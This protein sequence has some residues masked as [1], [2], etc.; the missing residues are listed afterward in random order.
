[1]SRW[2]RLSDVIRTPDDLVICRIAVEQG[3]ITDVQLK[4]CVREHARR[5]DRTLSTLMVEAGLLTTDQ[6]RKLIIEQQQRLLA[7]ATETA[8]EHRYCATCRRGFDE[9]DGMGRCPSCG[10]TLSTVTVA[11]PSPAEPGLPEEV[12]EAAQ[13]KGAVVGKF[14]R[15]SELGR[16]GM[17]SVWRCYDPELRRMVAIKF[18]EAEGEAVERF[19]KEARLA[20]RLEHPNIARVYEVGNVAG[21]HYIVMQYVPGRTMAGKRLSLE[22]ALRVMVKA[23]RAIHYAHEHGVIHRDLKPPNIMIDQSGE[24]YVLD[25]GLAKELTPGASS[26]RSVIM[27]TPAYMSYEQATGQAHRI[28]ARTDVYGLAATL[29]D[30]LTLRAP[31]EGTTAVEVLRKIQSEDPPPPRAL[32]PDLPWEVETILLKGLDREPARRYQSAREFADDLDR[33][34]RGDPIHAKRT[35][36]WYRLQKR[37]RRRPSLWAAGAVAVL[38]ALLAGTFALGA[39]AQRR[40]ELARHLDDGRRRLDGGDLKGAQESAALARAIDAAAAQS[41][42]D[43]VVRRLAEAD[44][45]RTRLSERERER[46]AV[47]PILR[48]LS[49]IELAGAN[50]SLRDG[51]REAEASIAQAR[52]LTESH[53]EWGS[54]W[55]AL[56]WAKR[57]RWKYGAARLLAE[58]ARD[59][60][61]RAVD[62]LEGVRRSDAFLQRGLLHA[63]LVATLAG[64]FSATI[65]D[66]GT[67]TRIEWRR[68]APDDAQSRQW[69]ARAEED[70]KRA[71]GDDSSAWAKTYGQ[72]LVLYAQGNFAQAAAR[73]EGVP[74]VDALV[75]RAQSRYYGMGDLSLL[76]QV[77]ALADLAD[78][79]DAIMLAAEMSISSGRHDRAEKLID[80]LGAI[81]RASPL[82]WMYRGIVRSQRGDA[83]GAIAAYTKVIEGHPDVPDAFMNR[84]GAYLDKRDVDAA[85]RDFAR[86]VELAPENAN[87]HCNLALARL[88]KRD[89]EPALASVERAIALDPG[90]A[91]AF[92]VRGRIRRV[93][94]KIPEA[95]ADYT[96]AIGIDPKLLHAWYNRGLAYRAA[97]AWKEAL[98]D[99]T[100]AVELNPRFAEGFMAR[101]STHLDLGKHDSAIGDYAKAIEIDPRSP[102]PYVQ[103]GSASE[104]LSELDA[105]RADDLLEAALRDYEHSLKIAPPGWRHRALVE[106]SVARVKLRLGPRR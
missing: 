89:L 44:D 31:Y 68:R 72:A 41:L 13:R 101:G 84:G 21:H 91:E 37:V 74:T 48:A 34:L 26:L 96:E 61:D 100:R 97:S 63:E 22:E 90:L 43:A 16:G 53:P 54:A 20:A 38:A 10:G 36:V 95:I 42:W 106:A 93:L 23:A 39:R 69:I 19:A 28:D 11:P 94:G 73:L 25:F 35:G 2:D 77:D 86:A 4:D 5:A 30:V 60:L 103:R 99:F 33:F 51:A 67:G 50:A 56:G 82:P 102:L 9:I 1:M 24:V 46:L 64:P 70:L 66:P 92:N 17:G 32:R 98:A 40:A 81:D 75:L 83:D 55:L 47:E 18:L 71:S 6:L 27:G 52:T 45:E 29:Y 3:L 76:R 49:T 58:E 87:A 14:V 15:I 7:M 59:H 57:L 80:R 8:N 62:R 88:E 79:R 78:R 85:L 12:R 104:M 105:D 65:A